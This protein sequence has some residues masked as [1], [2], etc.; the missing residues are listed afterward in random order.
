MLQHA[1]DD[2]FSGANITGQTDNVFSC[3]FF[4]ETTSL[5]RKSNNHTSF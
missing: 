3:P 1:P 2:A 4:Q 5:V